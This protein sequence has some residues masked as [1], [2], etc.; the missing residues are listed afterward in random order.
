MEWN[1]IESAFAIKPDERT[2]DQILTEQVAEI[3]L[4][5]SVAS[6]VGDVMKELGSVFTHS[7]DIGHM[8]SSVFIVLTKGDRGI[9]IGTLLIVVSL[10]LLTFQKTAPLQ[11]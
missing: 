2:R 3:P 6:Y 1:T 8:V 11:G 9:I 4:S 10:S 7:K 5:E